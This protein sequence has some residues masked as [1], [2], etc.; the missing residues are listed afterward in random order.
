MQ[1]LKY[2]LMHIYKLEASKNQVM[3][4]KKSEFII[5]P[6]YSLK[7]RHAYTQKD[8]SLAA[9]VVPDHK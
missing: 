8:P 9:A 6:I 5:L 2:F 7:T 3:Q 4:F 1:D